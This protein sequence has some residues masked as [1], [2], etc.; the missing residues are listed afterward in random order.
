MA[1]AALSEAELLDLV[2]ELVSVLAEIVVFVV[3]PEPF[4]IPLD[5]DI[6]KELE[7]RDALAATFARLPD[8]LRGKA[9]TIFVEELQDGDSRTDEMRIT[10]PIAPMTDG[11]EELLVRVRRVGFLDSRVGRVVGHVR[12]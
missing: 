11:A 1:A 7:E 6:R 10:E 4:E 9:R 8:D 12:W 5:D 2:G 3:E